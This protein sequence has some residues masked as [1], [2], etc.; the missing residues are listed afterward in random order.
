MMMNKELIQDV[1]D[2]LLKY[3][4]DYEEE[5]K[6]LN[7]KFGMNFTTVNSVRKYEPTE[8]KNNRPEP[9]ADAAK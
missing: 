5:L 4:S 9:I 1:I 3:G 6:K 2:R 8:F 7:E